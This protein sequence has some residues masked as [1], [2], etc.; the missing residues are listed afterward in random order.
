MNATAKRYD[1]PV[2][3]RCLSGKRTITARTAPLLESAR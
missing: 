2:G 3:V 1:F